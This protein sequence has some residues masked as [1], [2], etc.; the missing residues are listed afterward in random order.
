MIFCFLLSRIV[1]SLKYQTR[2]ACGVRVS[3]GSSPFLE[4]SAFGPSCVCWGGLGNGKRARAGVRPLAPRQRVPSPRAASPAWSTSF[5]CFAHGSCASSSPNL[6]PKQVFADWLDG[7]FL[8]RSVGSPRRPIKKSLTLTEKF[9]A[10]GY[11]PFFKR[12]RHSSPVTLA[13][14]TRHST[15]IPS[16]PVTPARAEYLEMRKVGARAARARGSASTSAP[17]SSISA[18]AAGSHNHHHR[19]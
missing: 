9:I 13:N 17:T 5:S 15:L 14:S 8:R 7:D 4:K 11:I 10:H 6:C 16:A 18:P 12:D 1:L 3:L 2:L 19:Q